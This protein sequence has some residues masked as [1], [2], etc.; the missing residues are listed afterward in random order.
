MQDIRPWLETITSNKV[1][2][3]A[4]VL[5]QSRAN[6]NRQVKGETPIPA[7][8]VVKIARVYEVNPIYGLAAAGII[9][10]EDVTDLAG[11][12]D[13]ALMARQL[14][15]DELLAEMQRRVRFYVNQMQQEYEAGYDDGKLG[16]KR[17]SN[18]LSAAQALRSSRPSKVPKTIQFED[19]S[20]KQLEKNN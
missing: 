5:G 6:L 1:S 16:R 12:S 7:A 18:R 9:S 8:T 20:P 15:D 13:N 2:Q 17:L 3:I 14:S 10:D 19:T 4:D 11:S